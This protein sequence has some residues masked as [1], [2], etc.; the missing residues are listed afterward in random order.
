MGQILTR[1][2]AI[3]SAQLTGSYTVHLDGGPS[4]KLL[5]RLGRL[6]WGGGGEHRFRRWNRCLQQHCPDLDPKGIRLRSQEVTIEEWEYTAIS[7]LVMRRQI[8][9]ECGIAMIQQDVNEVFFDI[10][11]NLEL[12]NRLAG[13][14]QALPEIGEPLVLLD[15]EQT[16]HETQQ[17]WNRW[18][19]AGLSNISPNLAPVLKQSDELEK[20]LNGNTY[21]S[22]RS[23]VNGNT[24]LRDLAVRMKKDPLSIT[25][26]L[27]PY[28]Q[29][30]MM[31]LQVVADAPEPNYQLVEL[32]I[33]VS[34][35]QPLI[36][37]IDDSVSVCQAM[38]EILTQAG[39]RF[40]AIHDSFQA[41]PTLLVQKPSLV[42]LD[43]VMPVA[44]G[45][46]ICSQIRRVSAL[47]D[48]PVVILTGNDGI[49]DRV[50][51]KMVGASDFLSKPV[52]P[53]KVLSVIQ[54]HLATQASVPAHPRN[55]SANFATDSLAP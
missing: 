25:R 7:V 52:E 19:G 39:Y 54:R 34:T 13:H 40:I 6:A 16:L 41:L 9:R 23:F 53:D 10:L 48:V 31:G 26:S 3:K 4:W 36:V 32:N 24:S 44:N 30:G 29:Q 47:K 27:A 28:F 38:G 20:R 33:P 14:F 11:Q 35:D 1:L 12:N 17:E 43:L 45:Y 50:R 51:A 37:C 21:I 8:S 15:P 46:E 22:L 2:Q 18:F 42:F 49:V 5:F 55:G